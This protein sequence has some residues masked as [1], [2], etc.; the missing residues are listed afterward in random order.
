MIVQ[1]PCLEPSD[2][3]LLQAYRAGSPAAF[4]TLYLRY[5]DSLYLYGRA[6]LRD[7]GLAEDLVNETFLRL[8][9]AKEGE[10]RAGSALGPLLHVILRRLAIDCRRSQTAARQR[11][12]SVSRAWLHSKATSGIAPALAEELNRALPR[13]PA[14]QLEVV[15]L[16]TYVGMTFQDVAGTVDAPLSTILSRYSYALKKLAELMKGSL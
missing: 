12:Q 14:E 16:H 4:E 11:E 15:I 7:D 3:D 5:R 6:L 10:H 8:L 1:E 13:L 9:G 2:A